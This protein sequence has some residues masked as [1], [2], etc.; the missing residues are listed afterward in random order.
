MKIEHW[1]CQSRHAD[2]ELSY[3]N[4]LAACLGGHGQPDHLPHCDTRKGERDLKF[5]PAG[6]AHRIEQRIY[7]ELDGTIGSSDADFNTQLH[8]V[9]GGAADSGGHLAPFEPVA[10]WWLDQRLARSAT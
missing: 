5:N 3:S 1:R 9:L 6:P 7:F 8:D 10:V 4:L 2:L